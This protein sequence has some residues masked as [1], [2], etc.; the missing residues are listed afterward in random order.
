MCMQY[1]CYTLCNMIFDHEQSR[2]VLKVTLFLNAM[3]V[4]HCMVH[5][6]IWHGTSSSRYDMIFLRRFFFTFH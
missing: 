2:E 3:F 5:D 6:V 1:Y 4:W